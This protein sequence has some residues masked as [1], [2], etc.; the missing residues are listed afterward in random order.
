MTYALIDESGR[1]SDPRDPVFVLAMIVS[2]N[3]ISLSKI[4]P[5]ARRS[6]AT[7]GKIKRERSL[8]EIK[9]SLVGDGSKRRVLTKLGKAPITCHALVIQKEG[10]SIP[11]D[12]ETLAFLTA[13]LVRYVDK[14]E[15]R[16]SHLLIDRHFTSPHQ[17]TL[18]DAHLTTFLRYPVFIEHLDSQQHTVIALA[19]FVAGAIRLASVKAQTTWYT[20]I[21]K[22][23]AGEEQISWKELRRQQHEKR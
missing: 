3:L 2:Q 8:P 18:F 11:D 7:K 17:R 14:Q 12:P 1:L 22:T 5:A 16:P 23:M 6:V 13:R 21:E 19:D 9:F 4:I 15:E 20:L 10:R